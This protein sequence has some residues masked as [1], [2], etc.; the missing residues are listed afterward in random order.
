[1]RKDMKIVRILLLISVSLFFMACAGKSIDPTQGSVIVDEYKEASPSLYFLAEDDVAS[2]YPQTGF[3]PLQDNLN[4]LMARVY[5][6]ENAKESLNLQYFIYA[7]DETAYA[8]TQLLVEAADRGVKVKILIDDLLQKDEDVALESLAQH[9]NIEIKLFNPTSIRSTLGF[10]QLAFNIDTLGRRM[11]NKLLVA[12]NS[13]AVIGGRNIENI[14]FAADKENIF[15]DNDVLAVGP[16]AAEASNEFATYWRSKISVDIKDVITE[17]TREDYKQ[18]RKELFKSVGKLRDNLYVDEASQREFAQKIKA[19]ELPLFYGD[20]HLYFDIPTKVVI[21][22]NDTTTHLSSQIKPL[23]SKIKKSLK[24]INP[25]FIPNKDMMDGIRALRE[26]GVEVY[27]VTNSLATND[28]IP[29]YSAYS[30]SQRELL[31]MG[32]HLYELNPNSFKYI[33]KNQKYRKGSIPRSSLHAKNMIFDDEIFVIGSMNL[34]P[35]SIKL[36]TEMLSVIHSKE[37]AEVEAEVFDHVRSPKNVFKLELEKQPDVKCEVT[38]IPQEDTR[39]V[40][41]TEENGEMKRYYHEG[42]AGFWRIIGSNLSRY[43][44]VMDKYL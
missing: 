12:D 8:I 22:E 30:R 6:I 5:L 42:N 40:W 31:K 19:N 33:Y 20:A 17:S 29:V 9:P 3:Y 7:E 13:A 38:C 36:N 18:L 26:R 44:P 16:L 10:V 2:H 4:A 27:I 14:Y 35:R 1:M 23:F 28:G 32:V 24:I 21:S 37:L 41:I 11:H 15:I 43:V 34:D 25:Y 39:V